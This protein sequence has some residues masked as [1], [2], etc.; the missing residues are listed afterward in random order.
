MKT[1]YQISTSSFPK[2]ASLRR[3]D[4]RF[5][6]P[7]KDGVFRNLVL[8]G[9]SQNLA[10]RLLLE[11]IAQEVSIELSENQSADV[12]AVLS[13]AKIDLQQLIDCLRPGGTLYYEV[14][15]R[16]PA[17]TI[18]TPARLV[19]I[20][21]SI[22]L[23]PVG[24]Y[25][26]APNFAHCRRFVPLDMPEAVD[27]YLSTLYRSGGPLQS[28]IELGLQLSSGFRSRL[29]ASLVPCYAFIATKGSG[30]STLPSVLKLPD[31][32]L[33][34]Q[35]PD[36]RP[37]LLTSG[38]DDGSRVIF[39]PFVPGKR[40]P[41]AVLKISTLPCLN[42]NTEHEQVILK[43]MYARLNESLRES[44]PNP[45]GLYHY[46]GLAVG[47]ESYAAGQPIQVSSGRW[48]R[49]MEQQI[50]DLQLAVHWLSKFQSQCQTGR[51][52]WDDSAV[53]H[54]IETPLT[55]FNSIFGQTDREARLFDKIRRRAKDL[56]GETMLLVPVHYDFGPWNLYRTE[57]KLTVID[58]EFDRSW[59][60]DRVGPALYDLL[61]FVT[62][63]FFLVK[64]LNDERAE[65]DGLYS[66]FIMPYRESSYTIA[67][68]KVITFYLKD[69]QISRQ[70]L[71]LM[72]VY[73][74]VE[75][76][77][78]QFSRKRVLGSTPY[79]ARINNRSIL[80]LDLLATHQ[81]LVFESLG[82]E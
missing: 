1:N 28:L 54:W 21:G 4:W 20:F 15:R 58:W 79:S 81:E 42:L 17:F 82:K 69:L 7:L 37:V 62:Y 10:E 13:G 78:Y 61:Y 11:G 75:Q 70:F 27:W 38:Q 73:F 18:S 49:S 9:G 31:L 59:E 25:I 26:A 12:V 2:W 36:L 39:L 48:R 33:N 16:L 29:L 19:R 43:E 14:D 71:P 65:L 56:I 5:L 55:R 32:P 40:Q 60:R 22:G 30:A 67:A 34:L 53:E 46:G 24:L 74:W 41:I 44:I 63:W 47:I 77:L 66:L 57:Q 23:D 51:F 3:V 6:L 76:A 45:L 52:I 50:G 8:L 68:H 80:Y 35:R 64:H 72:L